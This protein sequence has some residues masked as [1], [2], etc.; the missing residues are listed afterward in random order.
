MNEARVR[1]RI[2]RQR[3][4]GQHLITPVHSQPADLVRYLGAVQAQD[5]AGAKWAIGQRI[6]GGTDAQIERAMTAGS[7][8]RT[9]VLRPTWHLVVPGDLRWMLQLTAPRIKSAMASYDRRLELTD[10]VIRK[11]RAVLEKSL[12][13]GK[14]LTRAELALALRRA[15]INV[16]GTQRLAHLMMRA[17]LD[18]L[19]C[20]GGRRGAQFTY[21]LVDERVPVTPPLD[22][23]EA[24]LELTKRYFASRGPATAQDFAW[25]SGL[26][27]ADARRGVELAMSVLE[28]EVVNGQRCWRSA[29][30]PPVA[31]RVPSPMA[32]LLPNYDEYFI[33][34]RDRS[35]FGAALKAAGKVP[36][37]AALARHILFIN[38]Q[39][40][41][42]WKSV[43]ARDGVV[44]Q[45]TPLTSLSK[46]ER[47]AV[48][49]AA[50]RYGAFLETPVRLA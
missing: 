49:R 8:I 35:A 34:F 46:T 43:A 24:L 31:T 36:D 16:S 23:D 7:I 29:N 38:G 5:F 3:L 39:I 27:V 6:V 40:V 4:V 14:Q 15:R 37:S 42:G 26:T 17:E 22:R 2:A 48:S 10:A 28:P 25:W 1:Q 9:H 20:S 45:A 18:A 47:V 50:E 19:L 11:S 32:H 41:G 30:A 21:A 13:G 12:E 33:G 44:V